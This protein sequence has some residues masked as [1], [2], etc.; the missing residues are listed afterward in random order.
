MG[1]TYAEISGN[2]QR[3][4]KCRDFMYNSKADKINLVYHTNQTKR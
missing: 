4:G 1:Q 3:K 2:N